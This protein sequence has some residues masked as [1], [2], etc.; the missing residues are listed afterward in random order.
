MAR[1]KEKG[2]EVP[3][4]GE[5]SL[6][7]LGCLSSDAP[8]AGNCRDFGDVGQH[9]WWWMG[10]EGDGRGGKQGGCQ[11]EIGTHCPVNHCALQVEHALAEGAKAAGAV[12][13]AV[14]DSIRPKPISA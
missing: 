8:F 12:L 9:K 14:V 6:P 1:G 13:S 2:Y 4:L 11:P 5:R 10:P 3:W 7:C